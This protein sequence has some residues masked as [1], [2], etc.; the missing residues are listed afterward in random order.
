MMRLQTTE[1]KYENAFWRISKYIDSTIIHYVEN[2]IS[3]GICY[4]ACPAYHIDKRYAP[5]TIGEWFRRFY[6]RYMNIAGR[7]LRKLMHAYPITPENLAKASEYAYRCTN[8]GL[9]YMVCAA[10]IDSGALAC[11]TR[12][13]IREADHAP[14]ILKTLEELEV[15]G[16]Y[17]TPKV[18]E[19]YSKFIEEAKKILGHDVP[20]NDRD[21]AFL[22]PVSVVD[23]LFA[24][25]AVIG[26]MK[27]L[28][29]L[30]LS[31]TIP[32]RPIGI[33]PP[34]GY[35][36]GN[37]SAAAGMIRTL[38]AYAQSLNVK[39]ILVVDCGYMY[40]MLRFEGP[41]IAEVPQPC[42]I[43]SIVEVLEDYAERG[44]V[45]PVKSTDLV[46]WHDPCMLMRRGGV[47]TPKH[48]LEEAAILT[49]P[50]NHGKYATCCGGGAHM[51]FLQEDVLKKL[52]EVLDTNLADYCKK[53][54]FVR[55]IAEFAL[56]IAEH[57][58]EELLNT[59]AKV[60]L[61]A[62]TSCI[63]MIRKSVE[64]SALPFV[65]VKHISEYLAGKI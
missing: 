39:A 50:K 43:L 26:T 33:R 61:T 3:C 29:K 23:L 21:K 64:H 12:A 53:D 8:C 27:I 60:I 40:P 62:C 34:I 15:S 1:K 19:A 32:E 49:L 22:I 48:I 58:A 65:E 20:V 52:D 54:R 56:K 28:D 18:E 57:R 11:L 25:D 59:G 2:C 24:K 6:R 37:L 51:F 31:W 5:A 16:K 4:E 35:A 36:S 14:Q 10:G 41:Y 46:T 9:C 45:H 30:G 63:Y 7:I 13:L 55:E 44:L 17:L 47:E 38:Y 42:K